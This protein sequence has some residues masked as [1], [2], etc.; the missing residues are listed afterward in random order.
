M[1][2]LIYAIILSLLPI[3]ELRGGI[4]YAYLSGQPIWLAYVV[5][6]AANFLVGP[7]M[8]I[9]LET[10]HKLLIK[11][12]FYEKLFD[13]FIRRVR[14]KTSHLIEKYGFWGITIFV[15]IPLPV[16]GAY[17]GTVAAWL[18]GLDKKKSLLAVLA[19]VCISGIVVSSVL[20]FGIGGFEF[21][22]KKVG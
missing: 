22:Y 5:C 12:S 18:F 13:K 14:K 7:I 11:W 16:T 17:T 20:Y 15:A 10:L 1:M 9:F 21:L 2:T 8:F 19:G 4:P 6:V 3:A